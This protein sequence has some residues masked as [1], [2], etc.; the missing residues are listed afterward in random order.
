MEDFRS[1]AKKY[2]EDIYINHRNDD[3]T[4]WNHLIDILFDYVDEKI[5][6]CKEGKNGK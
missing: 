5:N 3:L 6:Q 1:S 2:V 4:A